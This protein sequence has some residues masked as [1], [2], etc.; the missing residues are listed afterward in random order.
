MLK[1]IFK[2][3]LM[4]MATFF[5]G[6]SQKVPITWKDRVL[7]S[8][9]DTLSLSYS[10]YGEKELKPTLVFLHGFGENRYTWRFLVPMLSE[11]YHLILLDLKGFG[12]SPKIDND[13]YSVYDQA[14]LVYQ[15]IQEKKLENITLVGH[16]F[17]GGVALVLALMQK[18]QFF[19]KKINKLV[20]IN[21]MAYNQNL[22][23][24][25]R[26]LTTPVIGYLGIH[27][28]SNDYL[29]KEAYRY[30]FYNDALIPKESL[31]YSANYLSF[32][33]AKYAY[34]KTADQLIPKD[35]KQLEKRFESIDLP[36][37]IL[38]G[39]EDISIRVDK[40]QRLHRALKQSSLK[41]FPHVGHMPQ[42]ESPALVSKEIINF[43]ESVQIYSD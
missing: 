34:I 24:M 11:K 21:S 3:L 4:V 18:E 25:L 1:I 39:N 16:S 26:N 38:W 41:L 13:Y 29:V 36:T 8:Q 37:L 20:L 2:F 42:E 22:P 33:N 23:S 7:H 40:A 9:V 12:D 5:I 31:A 10:E 19:D 35:I 17:G 30:A 43:M 15:F 32:D 14:Q 6:C 27:F 28:L